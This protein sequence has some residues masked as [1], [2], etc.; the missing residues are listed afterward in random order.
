M[1][2]KLDFFFFGVGWRE[3]LFNRSSKLETDVFCYILSATDTQVQTDILL[4]IPAPPPC[5]L[6]TKLTK[7]IIIN[8]ALMF[9]ITLFLKW[10]KLIL[11]RA[12]IYISEKCCYVSGDFTSMWKATHNYRNFLK[13]TTEVYLRI[14][15]L[16]NIGLP[17]C[18]TIKACSQSR[19]IV[20][21]WK[22]SFGYF[23]T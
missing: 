12:V 19:V 10:I 2:W 8:L 1:I 22:D 13:N 21:L 15:T 11:P 14:L 7:I 23:N 5:K 16:G 4:F 20:V 3:A 6:N 17:C 9:L 18:V